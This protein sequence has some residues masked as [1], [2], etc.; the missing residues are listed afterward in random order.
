MTDRLAVALA[1]LVDAL[2]EE[3]RSAA[4]DTN[5]PDRLLS[6]PEACAALGG[7]GRSSL[8]A[9]L[10]SGRV[11]SIKLGRRRL[12]PSGA[13]AAYINERA[14]PDRDSGAAHVDEGNA[15]AQPTG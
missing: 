11:R 5:A 10:G 8:Y 15:N 7:I 3:A 4:P 2:R 9:E 1:E 6:I 14:A 12:V 13:I